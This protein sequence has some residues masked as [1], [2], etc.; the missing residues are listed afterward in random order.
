MHAA[1]NLPSAEILS[2][3][4][5]RFLFAEGWRVT[6]VAVHD[7]G[8]IYD[9]TLTK[10]FGDNQGRTVTRTATSAGEATFKACSSARNLDALPAEE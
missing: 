5:D 1:P 9:V 6:D 2:R 7:G 8:A 4:I 3:Y 10:E